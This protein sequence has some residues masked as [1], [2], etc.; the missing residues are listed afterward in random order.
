MMRTLR[1]TKIPGWF[2]YYREVCPICHKTGGCIRNDEGDAVGCIRVPS[3]KIFGRNPMTYLHVLQEKQAFVKADSLEQGSQRLPDFQLDM[4]YRAYIQR[5][6]PL[7]PHHVEALQSYPRNLTG[8]QIETKGYCSITRNFASTFHVQGAPKGLPGFYLDNDTWKIVNGLEGILIPYR[9]V[10]NE[11]V[12]YQIRVDNP[13]NE[14]SI[15]QNNIEGLNLYLKNDNVTCIASVNGEVFAEV[16]LHMG[17]ETPIYLNEHQ[18]VVVKLKNGNRY[19]WLSSAKKHLGCGASGAVHLAMPSARLKV[20]ES[21]QIISD[22]RTAIRAENVWITEGALKGDIAAEHI[23]KAFSQSMI[24]KLGDTFLCVAGV[25]SW[26]AIMP[27]LKEL[28]T[29]QV[30]IAFDMDMLSNEQVKM[31]IQHLLQALK[32]ERFVINYAVWNVSDG[33]GIDDLF[34]NYKKPQIRR[35][36]Y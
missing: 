16:I 30:T 9:N 10:F 34:A 13:R 1:Q 23:S 21:E 17:V 36:V 29:K 32:N 3:E 27:V 26:S 2:E 7:L 31:S 20:V 12:G 5:Q 15:I 14:V 24:E 25:N 4:L 8:E 6:F 22:T 35:M 11:I 33:K 19:W 28:G 18:Q